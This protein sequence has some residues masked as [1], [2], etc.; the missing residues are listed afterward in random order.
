MENE[1][2]KQLNLKEAIVKY[3]EFIGNVRQKKR[4]F[5]GLVNT[6]LANYERNPVNTQYVKK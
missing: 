5:S 1:L 3:Q 4:L 6:F 2:K